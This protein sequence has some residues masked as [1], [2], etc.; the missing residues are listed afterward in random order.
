M[1]CFVDLCLVQSDAFRPKSVPSM[2]PAVSADEDIQNGIREL[3][4]LL[5]GSEYM[6]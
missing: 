5:N 6:Q 2:P 3:A 1:S 4:D